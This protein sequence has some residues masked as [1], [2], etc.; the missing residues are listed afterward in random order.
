MS[1]VLQVV[2]LT[3]AGCLRSLQACLT[4]GSPILLEG[5]GSEVHPDVEAA[6]QPLLSKQVNKLAVVLHLTCTLAT[7]TCEDM[8]GFLPFQALADRPT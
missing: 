6:L 7:F 3:D 8:R 1:F 5:F 4:L 2:R